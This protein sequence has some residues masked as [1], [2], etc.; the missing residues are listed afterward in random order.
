MRL[1]SFTTL[2]GNELDGAKFNFLDS[3]RG[4]DDC[5][6]G[7]PFNARRVVK[8]NPADK[9]LKEIGPDL[10]A[11]GMRWI[12]GVM[13]GNGSI[14]CIPYY[15][16]KILKIDT[17]NETVTLL[18]TELPERGM[19]R[20]ISGALAH[21]GCI[22]FMPQDARRIL[23]FNPEDESAVSVGEDLGGQ[24]YKYSGTVRGND[25]YLCGIP[26]YSNL[27]VRYNPADRSMTLLGEEAD[28]YFNCSN[29]VMG[30]DGHIYAFSELLCK[31]LR[32]DVKN[33]TYSFVDNEFLSQLP[34]RTG[35]GWGAAILGN[36][37]CIYWPPINANRTLKFDPETQAV[38]LVGN[39][40]GDT[41]GKW[42]SGAAAG[43]DGAIY[44]IPCSA[45]RVL[46][47]DPFKEFAMKIQAE[48]EQ[49]PEELG[50]LF[51]KK[52]EDSKT[53]YECA[54]TK[55][56][57]EKVSEVIQDCIPSSVV[58]S[59]S[60]LPSFIVA[61]TYKNSPVCIIYYLLRKNLDSSS[62]VNRGS[63]NLS[64][65]EDR[66]ESKKRKER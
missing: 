42:S 6:Y 2:V 30:R 46:A 66:E 10:G 3:V 33:N 27:I 61:A 24:R 56:G 57:I 13:A 48:M 43:P 28:E 15:S 20:W 60:H 50:R 45:T 29:G 59:G 63:D 1:P 31:M 7:I 8:I 58:I 65:E 9:S 25:G 55:F 35:K 54:V 38:S 14:Y 53:T 41:F 5:I 39:D 32:I 47:I 22:Y 64:C 44:C 4:A 11:D 34:K 17:V 62:L 36:D 16:G 37:G 12:C 19:A 51:R 52:H 21:D 23:K 18:D 26:F 49:Y 40:F